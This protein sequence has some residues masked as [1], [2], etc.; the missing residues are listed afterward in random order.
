MT[1][2][3][4]GTPHFS[5]GMG[6]EVLVSEAADPLVA[7]LSASAPSGPPLAASARFWWEKDWATLVLAAPTAPL[8]FSIKPEVQAG[9]VHPVKTETSA[10]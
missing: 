1:V 9:A 10:A 8:A 6:C 7:A 3:H 5:S 2:T 4:G